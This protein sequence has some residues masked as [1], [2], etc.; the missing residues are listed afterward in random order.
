MVIGLKVDKGGTT[1]TR[2]KARLH[3]TSFVSVNR[4]KNQIAVCVQDPLARGFTRHFGLG[5]F[6]SRDS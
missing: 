2:R 6:R 1:S 4:L 5:L 3:G